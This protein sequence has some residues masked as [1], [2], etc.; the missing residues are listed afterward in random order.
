MG[1]LIPSTLDALKVP[2][3]GLVA[4]GENPRRGD[5]SV[6][7]ESL[8]RHGQYRPIVVRAKTFE[9]LAGNHTLAAAKELGWSEIAATFVDCTDDEAARIVLVD[10]RSADLGVYDDRVLLELLESLGEDLSGTGFVPEDIAALEHLTAGGVSLD[11]LAE[12]FGEPTEADALVRVGLL[13]PR[14]LA[15]EL[16]ARVGED[17]ADHEAFAR[18]GLDGMPA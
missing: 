17:V 5:V 9:V 13:L 12:E 16:L 15:E 2:V 11:D 14:P 8:E 6:I 7:V 18:A 3:E 10:N 4:Y 1:D